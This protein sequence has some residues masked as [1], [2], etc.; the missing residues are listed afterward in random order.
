V[1]SDRPLT[2]NEKKKLHPNYIQ[3][4]QHYER[5]TKRP[6]MR[7]ELIVL[8]LL[9]E[10]AYPAQIN[11]SIDRFFKLAPDRFTTLHYIYRPVSNMFKNKRGGNK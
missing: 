5:V 10:K 2:W 8:K 1:F 3:V 7:E 11:Q 6:F 4:I 9:V